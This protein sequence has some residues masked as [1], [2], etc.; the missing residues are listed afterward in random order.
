M[1]LV[2]AR[3]RVPREH[4]DASPRTFAAPTVFTPR[5]APR[6]RRS[7]RRGVL[8]A[9]SASRRARRRRSRRGAARRG[10]RHRP[11]RL[12]GSPARAVP[13]LA[14]RRD[15]PDPGAGSARPRRRPTTRAR[16]RAA[17]PPRPRR[18]PRPP[19]R[20]PP[21][22]RA[23]SPPFLSRRGPGHADADVR[24]LVPRSVLAPA[25]PRA[26]RGGARRRPRRRHGGL[27]RD[28]GAVRPAG[29]RRAH[30]RGGEAARVPR[31]PIAPPARVRP[32]VQTLR[33]TPTGMVRRQARRRGHAVHPAVARGAGRGDRRAAGEDDV[34]A[35]A[36]GGRSGF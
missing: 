9:M 18:P 13:T 32:R 30:A 14:R 31:P 6:G 27:R 28:D 25:V 4:V 11:D 35:T 22:L 16:A 21:L 8:G 2:M 20:P 33:E 29:E 26:C 10:G 36:A 34:I 1:M 19:P 23:P 7:V 24:R 17:R 5:V 15:G 12:A 3:A